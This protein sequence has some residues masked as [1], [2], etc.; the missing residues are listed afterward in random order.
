MA[1]PRIFTDVTFHKQYRE[2]SIATFKAES[3]I[4]GIF[5]DLDRIESGFNEA[6]KEIVEL[7]AK[8]AR[9]PS[10]DELRAYMVEAQSDGLNFKKCETIIAAL[11]EERICFDDLNVVPD[12][13][14]DVVKY[15]SQLVKDLVQYIPASKQ[16][17]EYRAGILSSPMSLDVI[18]MIIWLVTHKHLDAD[19]LHNFV[20]L[21]IDDC[22]G[23]AVYGRH[24]HK[25]RLV[26]L[27]IQTL[28][29]RQLIQAEDYLIEVSSFCLEFAQ[30]KEATTLY[31]L[32][33][34]L[35]NPESPPAH[36]SDRP[37]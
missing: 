34:T 37:S 21:C 30:I 28:L 27:F 15:N 16:W 6:L 5:N 32:L 33:L 31:R 8:D 12:K 19:R 10:L 17:P 11:A 35:T 2:Y 7:A 26:S 29:Q 9:H 25:A 4:P 13:I 23:A 24:H 3:D 14:D 1:H 18:E 36:N 22:K 20:T